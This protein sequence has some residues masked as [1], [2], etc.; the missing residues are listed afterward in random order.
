MTLAEADA[1]PQQILQQANAAHKKACEKSFPQKQRE[2][3]A[4]IFFIEIE[5]NTKQPE[6][7]QKRNSERRQFASGFSGKTTELR[8]LR[9]KCYCQIL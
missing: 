4:K 1:Q 8:N 6:N 7:C 5:K 9:K 3:I 2:I